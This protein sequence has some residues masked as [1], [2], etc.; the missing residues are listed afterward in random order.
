MNETGRL[1]RND[2]KRK[3]KNLE[4]HEIAYLLKMT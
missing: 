4:S 1:V 3:K 2:Q